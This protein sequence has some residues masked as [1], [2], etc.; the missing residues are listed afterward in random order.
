MLG[1]MP[2]VL[3]LGAQGMLGSMVADVLGR[4]PDLD[5]RVTVR[6]P[7]APTPAGVPWRRFDA[8]RD[9]LAAVLDADPADWVVNAI[10]ITASRINPRDSDSVQA[11]IELNALFPRRLA[12]AAGARGQRVI[13]IATDGVYSGS[14]GPYD[15]TDAHD[16]TDVYGQTKSLGEVAA[17]NVVALRCSIVGPELATPSSLLGRTLAAP[18]SATLPGFTAQSWNGLTTLHFARLCA[19]VIGGTAVTEP[20]H[21][22]PAGSVT[23]AELL[24]LV[25]GAFARGDLTI[26]SE[27]GPRRLDRRLTTVRPDVN[28]R[29]WRAAG[30][31]RPPTIAAMV[32]ELAAWA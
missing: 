2:K 26:A 31:E 19:A 22:V 5:V 27:P 17:D 8:R 28:D 11:A 23:K 9:S 14:D 20:Q 7:S 1:T 25:V 16:A 3:V 13:Q 15:E 29:L 4:L 18:W 12:Q 10:A 32:Q 6:D 30:Y 21:V 24:A